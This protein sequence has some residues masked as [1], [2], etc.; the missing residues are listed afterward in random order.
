[1]KE[2]FG[3][4]A[5]TWILNAVFFAIILFAF[6][7]AKNSLKGEKQNYVEYAP[8]LM[9]SLGLFGT[10]LGIFIG[11]LHFDAKHIDGSIEQLL[12]G[13]QTAFVTSLIG[14][15]FAIWFKI[16][17]TNYLDKQQPVAEELSSDDVSPNDI[18]AVLSKQHTELSTIAKGIG[19][20]DERSM[21]GRDN[22]RLSTRA[23]VLGTERYGGLLEA[24]S[25]WFSPH[26][27]LHWRVKE[28]PY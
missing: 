7:R 25:R 5:F 16:I 19:G 13:L 17:Q 10:F 2:F 15:F 23:Q 28:S 18:F 12:S 11:L 26:A 4:P 20:N 9:T 1:M 21:V 8:S 14:M 24:V 22:R 3:S 27:R 6:L